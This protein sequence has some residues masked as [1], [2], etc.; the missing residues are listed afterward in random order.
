MK[1]YR[2][3]STLMSL[4]C[5]AVTTSA[6]S[7]RTPLDARALANGPASASV[8][9]ISLPYDP[10]KP[11]VSIIV[12]S[13]S[14]DQRI[15]A[16]L[17]TTLSRVGNF[18]LYDSVPGGKA[19]P[20]GSQ[21]GP[22]MVRASTTEYN[23]LAERDSTSRDFS[24]GWIGFVAAI[25]GAVTG[26]PGLLW[27][28][29]GV[30]AANPEYHESSSRTVGMVGLDI[31]IIDVNTHRILLSFS[32]N[33]RFVTVDEQSSTQILGIGGTSEHSASSALGQAQRIALNDV[34]QKLHQ[35]LLTPH[36]L[37]SS[38]DRH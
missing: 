12:D 17:T 25:A 6:C 24:F 3:H 37:D 21:M 34:A 10:T 2:C 38:G 5:L 7:S 13:T 9:Q 36:E 20:R 33:G 27:S 4:I 19:I 22:Y 31:Q 14:C 30:A 1:T 28:G 16:Q 23:E 29:V 18:V 32:A 35:A 11:R 8:E 26:E 15:A